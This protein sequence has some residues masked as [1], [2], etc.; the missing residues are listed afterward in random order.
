LVFLKVEHLHDILTTR[1]SA[2]TQHNVKNG[3]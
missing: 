2:E 3:V 1:R